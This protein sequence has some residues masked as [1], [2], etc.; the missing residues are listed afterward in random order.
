MVLCSVLGAG[1]AA[2]PSSESKAQLQQSFEQSRWQQLIDTVQ[3]LPVH[4]AD[5]D[6]F[7]G[8]ALAQLG[9]WQE[10]RRALLDG[11]RLRP[12]DKRFPIELAGVAF[13]QKRYAESATWLRRGLQIDPGDAYAN[14]FLGTVYFIEG[15]LEAALKYWNRIGKPHIAAV[16][17]E[18]PLRTRPALLDRRLAFAAG[19]QLELPDLLTSRVRIG[20]LGVFV[21]PDVR[22]AARNGGEFD[23]VL[24]LQERNGFGSNRWAALASVFSGA[25]YKTIYPQ[26]FNFRQ[27]A[28]NF[29]SLVRWDDEKRRA[30][31]DV[32]G[33]FEG[34]RKRSYRIGF[35]LRNENWGLRQSFT[36]TA[37]VLATLNLR[38][39]VAVAEIRSVESGAWQWS[40]GIEI[41]DR[42]YR[43]V[44]LGTA[45][46]PQQ[47][48]DGPQLKALAS[49]DHT[50]WRVPD[51]RLAVEAS[52]SAQLARI[53]SQSSGVYSQ[54]QGELA[55]RWLPKI[56]GDDFRTEVRIHGGGSRG[57]VP[58]DQ[59]YML[60]MERDNDLWLRAHI[61]TR[62]GIKGSAPLGTQYLLSNIDV[63]KSLYSNGL[64]TVK[65]S[66]FLD[67]GTI[68]G[69]SAQLAT[70]KWLWDTGLELK[71]RVLG[72]GMSFVWGRDL[73]MGN[74]AFYF[75][76]GR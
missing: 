8:S 32:T 60:G 2:A 13:K 28:I 34:N 69:V 18:Q 43:S 37:P 76:S 73:R 68:S 10:S 61:G 45:L 4:D 39:A 53:W 66:P 7:Y 23:A 51:H 47:L 75:A 50:L 33:P 1:Q 71:V 31:L 70:R 65:L 35:D 64:I 19:E 26:Y 14:D 30:A 36:G 27:S 63:D 46:T 59:L 72:V 16:T 38:R 22:L 44:S 11:R 3:N 74:N 42:D 56:E 5:I 24:N 57:S 67:T 17:R 58:F 40:T 55:A 48:I 25:A 15:N 21:A 41:S 9:R 6:Y 12:R 54:L 49:S 29:R 62:D 52:L 20:N